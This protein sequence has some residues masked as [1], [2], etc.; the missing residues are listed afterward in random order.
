MRFLLCSVLAVSA[1]GFFAACKD[2]EPAQY[3]NQ[4]YPNQQYPNQQYPQQQYPQQQYP[5]Q[6]YPQ[7]TQ[8]AAPTAS[9][10]LGVPIPSGFPVP[11]GL[12]STLPNIFPTATAAPTQ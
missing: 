2:E 10:I 12:P 7:Q 5:Q 8:T 4:Q 11:S 9:T 1:L 6:Q 3:P